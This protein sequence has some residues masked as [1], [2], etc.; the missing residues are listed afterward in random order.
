MS[1][2]ARKGAKRVERIAVS[3]QGTAFAA[4]LCRVCGAAPGPTLMLTAAQH[5]DEWVGTEV[6]RRLFDRL[7]QS[8]LR[9]RLLA[10]PVVNPLAMKQGTPHHIPADAPSAQRLSLQDSKEHRYNMGRGWPGDEQGD[11]FARARAAIWRRGVLQSDAVVDLHCYSRNNHH[12]VYVPG[13]DLIELAKVLDLGL[14]ADTSACA[15]DTGFMTAVRKAGKAV[16]TVEFVGSRELIEEEVLCGLRAVDNLLKHLGMLPGRARYGKRQYLI[17][18]G[19]T[20]NLLLN[21]PGSGLVVNQRAV[22]DR[23]G[24]GEVLCEILDVESGAIRG[25]VRSPIAGVVTYRRY[26]NVVSEGDLV[27]AVADL[28]QV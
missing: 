22:L 4:P 26:R 13:R 27:A 19:R 24:E 21:A 10:F 11:A 20:E 28:E 6:I 7:D 12:A 2:A 1:R 9:G 8:Q 23:V 18:S 14:I 5:G 17:E 15:V 3:D 25:Q 16:L